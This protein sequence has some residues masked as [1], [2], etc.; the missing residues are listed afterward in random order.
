[1]LLVP[2]QRTKGLSF[3]VPHIG[4]H[5]KSVYPITG[6]VNIDHLVKVMHYQVSLGYNYFFSFVAN[7]YLVGRYFFDNVNSF[8]LILPSPAN[9]ILFN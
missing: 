2:V 1:M 5:M 6:D 8:F 4:K 3:P 7:T 9:A